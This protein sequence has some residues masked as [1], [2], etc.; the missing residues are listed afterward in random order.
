[1][2]KYIAQASQS[3]TP[4]PHPSFALALEAKGLT[5]IDVDKELKLVTRRLVRK[6]APTIPKSADGGTVTY[7]REYC[8]LNALVYVD[9][10]FC[11]PID[12]GDD[13]PDAP[14]EPD[15]TI[16][17]RVAQGEPEDR[18][19]AQVVL[20]SCGYT[21]RL[22]DLDSGLIVD[23]SLRLFN[24]PASDRPILRA[25]AIAYTAQ[26]RQEAPSCLAD[27]LPSWLKPR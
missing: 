9:P 17:H 1:M 20:T 5:S 27:D 26:T 13:E 10:V 21:A 24:G 2:A 3:F 15:G 7:L 16:V 23:G 11:R 25:R 22:V 12:L 19:E 8:R 6:I 4:G 14:G 18:M